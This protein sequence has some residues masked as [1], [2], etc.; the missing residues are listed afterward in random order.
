MAKNETD[1][2]KLFEGVPDI[3]EEKKRFL[4][5]ALAARPD[6]TPDEIS[7]LF[8]GIED[9]ELILPAKGN[10]ALVPSPGRAFARG[11]AETA[12][13]PL[14]VF[15]VEPPED[16][17]TREAIEA[18]VPVPIRP[19]APGAA[20][21]LGQL[22]GFGL[23][24]PPLLK[25][26]GA[27]TTSLGLARTGEKVAR[28]INGTLA[29]SAF[30]AGTAEELEDVP[31]KA[32]I[33]AGIGLG[34][35]LALPLGGKLIKELTGARPRTGGIVPEEIKLQEAVHP[36]GG[37][38][39]GEVEAF[40]RMVNTSA[41]LESVAAEIGLRFRDGV[42]IVP[43]E[44]PLPFIQAVKRGWSD[45]R[46]GVFTGGPRPQVLL[47]SS[48][49][50]KERLL[51]E[52]GKEI[53]EA[54]G[55]ELN[56]IGDFV[57]GGTG[58][59][60]NPM[61]I[62]QWAKLVRDPFPG[63]IIQGEIELSLR[64]AKKGSGGTA[65]FRAITPDAAGQPIRPRPSGPPPEGA[66][67]I[68]VP[69]D[70]FVPLVRLAKPRKF[71]N[72]AERLKTGVHEYMH[73]FTW[74]L[75]DEGAIRLWRT[76][77]ESFWRFEDTTIENVFNAFRRNQ[78]LSPRQLTTIE[79]E[80]KE[81]TLHAEWFDLTTRPRNLEAIPFKKLT[82]EN[83]ETVRAAMRKGEARAGF[84]EGYFNEST[85]LL[86]RF[87]EILFLSPET[88]RAVAPM[89]T[90]EMARL[91][92]EAGPRLEQMLLRQN[93][94][95]INQM[96]RSRYVSEARLFERV[97]VEVGEREVRQFT[98]T[99]FF[100]GM[101]VEVGGQ[102]RW[103]VLSV[104]KT[105]L[106]RRSVTVRKLNGQGEQVA[107][108]VRTIDATRPEVVQTP[109]FPQRAA[110]QNDL[111]KTTK[112]ALKKDPK[113]VSFWTRGELSPEL[114]AGLNLPDV[115]VLRRVA[116]NLENFESV[117]NLVEFTKIPM[118][119]TSD[120]P[121]IV[122]LLEDQGKPG[123][124]FGKPGDKRLIVADKNT[125]REGSTF[126]VDDG[127]REVMREV[128]FDAPVALPLRDWAESVAIDAGARGTDV[129]AVVRAIERDVAEGTFEILDPATK[130]SVEAGIAS[131]SKLIRTPDHVAR[132]SNL[133]LRQ[134]EGTKDFRA[135]SPE[136]EVLERF[137]S[138]SEAKD[139]LADLGP[140][141][142]EFDVDGAATLTSRL[143]GD[144]GGGT[145]PPDFG[146]TMATRGF[147]ERWYNKDASFDVPGVVGRAREA[148]AS[149]VQAVARGIDL[150]FP[151]ATSARRF[152][153]SAQSA[154][155]G[156]AEATFDLGQQA[157]RKVRQ[158][159]LSV[160]RPILGGKTFA[161]QL[162]IIQELKFS[163]AREAKKL[164]K[165]AQESVETVTDF[166]EFATKQEIEKA[167]G[168]INRAMNKLEKQLSED[169]TKLGIE[170]Q[171]PRLYGIARVM[172]G[173][174]RDGEIAEIVRL[175]KKKLNIPKRPNQAQKDALLAEMFPRF[176]ERGTNDWRAFHGVKIADAFF[177]KGDLD[178]INPMLVMRHA[179]APS[180][181]KGFTTGQ[182][183]FAAERKLTGTQRQLA[184]ETEKLFNA[185]FDFAGLDSKRFITG[186]WP[187]IRELQKWGMGPDEAFIKASIPE[188][189][190]A[191]ALRLRTG[192]LDVYTKDPVKAAFKHIRGLT[193]KKH[194]DPVLPQMKRG[195]E[196]VRVRS[197]RIARLLDEYTLELMGHPHK[198]FTKVGKAVSES[199]AAMG[200]PVTE[201]WVEDI[202]NDLLSFAY[203]AT[204][205]YRPAL[206][207]RNYFQLVQT[208]P[209][210]VGWEDFFEGVARTRA[211]EGYEHAVKTGAV[212]PNATPLEFAERTIDAEMRRLPF[213]M[214]RLM[215]RG[216]QWYRDADEYG[217]SVALHGQRSRIEK[218]IGRH[219]TRFGSI[220]EP[221]GTGWNTFLE[222]AKVMTFSQPE[223]ATFTRT[224]QT[225]GIEAAKDYLGVQ[226]AGDTMF[227]YGLANHPAGW[228]SIYGRMFGQFGTW[229]VQ[230]KDFF[231][232]GMTRGT[233]KDKAEF[234]ASQLAVNAGLMTVPAAAGVNMW[235][236]VSFPSLAYTGG[237]YAGAALD[238]MMMVGGSPQER[239][240]A[241]RDLFSMFP[242]LDDPRSIFIPGSYAVGDLFFAFEQPNAAKGFGT[243][244]GLRFFKPGDRTILDFI[245]P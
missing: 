1:V 151:W 245:N 228:G 224:W 103:E 62:R 101:E 146:E 208:I 204:I 241:R 20:G 126:M 41:D 218:A 2:R 104:G 35:E 137:K 84:G 109:T 150:L 232:Q 130:A 173:A 47:A 6:L 184:R 201:T 122:K 114:A 44:N 123:V 191:T 244:A 82:E 133:R 23:V 206:I 141:P 140:R 144:G 226:L 193:M 116:V 186:Y 85:E 157:M 88:A 96:M 203:G 72:E 192:E 15:G 64:G 63:D 158:E 131:A 37:V 21:L 54:T 196:A 33:G 185:S 49:T 161:E 13:A 210:R 138:R 98:K 12:L 99:G 77:P 118:S 70:Q 55:E 237:P 160:P 152:F 225:Q 78:P 57:L 155:F 165:N 162:A 166:T 89:A 190:D 81:V 178:V 45:V 14:R 56:Q 71:A 38:N 242:T 43:T 159:L 145:R 112:E 188:F 149:R 7:K 93:V 42:V 135:E 69:A 132:A 227:R 67:V 143:F 102:G 110:V 97:P 121:R 83:V 229:P 73:V 240:L 74:A 91:I 180:L 222:D 128:N 214:K 5:I 236:W 46:A 17:V 113:T 171:M 139:Y 86:S 80:L 187:H 115:P 32:A 156:P 168:L 172:N 211:K 8:E 169:I 87:G 18:G 221:G 175:T 238:L 90:R 59:L 212:T 148:G 28:V 111:I 182:Q 95:V 36:E 179:S 183:M 124:I 52:I 94:K 129:A 199:M 3:E 233:A 239:Q 147:F 75:R 235:S 217:R 34:F 213:K 92:G 16:A 30:E 194:F 100:R 10:R 125:V 197:E 230:F 60:K 164:G 216:F 195:T 134:S 66:E 51:A 107:G 120:F 163:V 220:P 209:S 29:F 170:Q 9:P 181:K 119:P 108:T 105:V 167:G 24:F 200:R 219:R 207:A 4:D 117:E 50:T 53:P 40:A 19:G 127:A 154:G 205:P 177:V 26:A 61:T 11:V 176:A 65:T 223:I 25:G 39:P 27:V 76:R 142:E 202:M 174:T 234:L 58:P 153:Q 79:N 136:G 31:K 189:V 68:E 48:R 198:S 231:I 22:A 243:A 106:G 215:N